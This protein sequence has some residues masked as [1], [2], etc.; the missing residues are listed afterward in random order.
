MKSE[1]PQLRELVNEAADSPLMM[2]SFELGPGEPL[3]VEACESDTYLFTVAG[4]AEI[5][6]TSGAS[7]KLNVGYAAF[8]PAGDGA[9]AHA[10][11][12]GLAGLRAEVTADCDI[13]APLGA[14]EYFTTVEGTA[15]AQATSKRTFQVLFG[16]YNGSCRATLFVGYVPPGKAPWHFHQYD[17]IVW[18]WKGHGRFHTADDQR[19]MSQASAVRMRPRQIHTLENLSAEDEL[20]LI[21]LFTPAG[22]PAAAFLAGDQGNQL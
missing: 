2:S 7:T 1:A 22:S 17:E 11:T 6:L 4:S 12:E 18:I 14:T 5:T 21:G 8:I 19:D 15:T 13:H 10:S 3:T 16:P 20:L 9:T